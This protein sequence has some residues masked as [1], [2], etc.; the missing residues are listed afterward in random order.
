HHAEHREDDQELAQDDERALHQHLAQHV[1]VPGGAEHEVASPVRGV[2]G[3]G[4]A[5]EMREEPPAHRVGEARACAG[6]QVALAVRAQRPSRTWRRSVSSID[7]TRAALRAQVNRVTARRRAARASRARKRGRSRSSSRC[8][9]ILPTL[10]GGWRR[11]VFR[12]ESTSVTWP[13][14]LATIG[15]PAAMYSYTLSG[16]KENLE[17]GG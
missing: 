16:E 13:M 3:E 8:A 10:P 4:E 5:L 9:T 1:R 12:W 15:T 14:A 7:S 17:S 6:E 2:D 11:A